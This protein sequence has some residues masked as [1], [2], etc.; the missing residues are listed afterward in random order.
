MKTSEKRT[1]T[2]DIVDMETTV[3][4]LKETTIR[5]TLRRPDE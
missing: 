5:F 2:K 4:I 1:L 3:C